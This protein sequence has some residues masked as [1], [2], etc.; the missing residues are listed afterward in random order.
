MEQAVIRSGGEPGKKRILKKIARSRTLLEW[1]GNHLNG[2]G[3]EI[4]PRA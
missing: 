3:T 1:H 4:F 2:T